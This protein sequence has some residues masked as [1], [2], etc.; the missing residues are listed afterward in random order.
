M[1]PYACL[2]PYL[3]MKNPRSFMDDGP[4]ISKIYVNQPLLL[5]SKDNGIKSATNVRESVVGFLEFLRLSN[6]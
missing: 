2:N 1:K 6:E 3:E 5:C 4:Q